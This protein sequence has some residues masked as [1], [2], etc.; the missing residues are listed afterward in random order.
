MTYPFSSHNYEFR[1][2]MAAGGIDPDHDVVMTVVPPP[3]T[4]DAMAAGAIDGFCVNAPWNLMAVERGVGRVVATKRDIWPS[5]PEKVLAVRPDWAE[6]HPE[7]LSRLIV[8]LEGAA[9]WC[10]E[11]ENRGALAEMLA[12]PAYVGVPA[13]LFRSLL[14]GRFQVDPDGTTREIPDYL[15]FHRELATFPWVSQ[16]EWIYSQMVRWGQVGF[17]EAGRAQVA[18]AYRPDLYRAALGD[19]ALPLEAAK[20][21]GR[22]EGATIA[23]TRGQVVLAPD[24]FIDG[25]SFDPA[26]MATYLEGFAIRHAQDPSAATAE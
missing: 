16:A 11:P 22:A 23:T 7:E 6:A 21:E 19:V 17:S 18:S 4:A 1:F 12:D 3:M 8:A 2:F 10:D 15:V 24:P 5:A 25:R 20:V 13:G 9:R 26:A 14:A